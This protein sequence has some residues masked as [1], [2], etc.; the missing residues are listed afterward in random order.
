MN[1]SGF[2]FALGGNTAALRL[3]ATKILQA[4]SWYFMDMLSNKV[5]DIL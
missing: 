5:S 1:R 4:S 3:K 2:S